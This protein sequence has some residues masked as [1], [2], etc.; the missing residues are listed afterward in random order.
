MTRP[1]APS[2]TPRRDRPLAGLT[3]TQRETAMGR[4]AVLRPHLEDGVAL[5]VTARAGGVPLRTAQRWLARYRTD[6]LA[7]LARTARADRGQRRVPAD[8]VRLVEGLAVSRPRPSVA[9]IARRAA[10]AAAEYG[11]PVASY[12]TVHAIVADL[13]P[14]LL[15]LAHDGPVGLRDRYEL[16][17]RRQAER[18]NMIWQADHTELDLLVL[19]ANGT[20]ARPWLTIVEDDCSRA[21]AGYTVFLGAPS[22]LNLSLA[23]RQAIWR[24]TD[25]DWAVH[26]IPEVLYTDH[27]SDFTSDHLAQ[28]AADLHIEL[29]HSTVGRP[30]GRGKLER[31]FGSITTELLPELPGH[32]VRGT[33][34]SAP[35]LTL[36]QLDAA[37]GR[38]ITTDYHQRPH[39]ETG[40]SPRQAWLADGWLP[41]TSESLEDLDLLLV[42][43]ATPRRVHRDG[44]RFQGL[45]YL[46]PTLAAYVGEPVT[47][48]YDPRDLGEIRVFHRNRFLCRGI[49]PEHSGQAITLKDIQTARSAHR[50]DL[51]EQ[52]R[53]RR[54]AVAEYLPTHPRTPPPDDLPEPA[55]STTTPPQTRP[56]ETTPAAARSRPRL[57][58]YLEDKA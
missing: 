12:S 57:L 45:R 22:S 28:V 8:L 41:R 14:H 29:V 31:L 1:P 50:R 55:P 18:P 34:A 20:P 51:R 58:T 10:R 49:S 2:A 48:R 25:P 30:Q 37:L 53:Q 36:P 32:L 13:D 42:M 33:P 5:A 38:W 47:I 15:T 27:G 21:V 17:Y 7:G 56:S 19:D 43:V 4:W 9:T 44:I 40:L 54:A 11:W 26:G 3:D 16:V 23:L 6:G 52:L 35:A 24:K 39:R 46:D